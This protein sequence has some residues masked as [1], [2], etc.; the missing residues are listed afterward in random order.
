MDCTV[1]NLYGYI[2]DFAVLCIHLHNNNWWMKC[3]EF[4]SSTS[5]GQVEYA[6][7]L[8]W[9]QSVCRGLK[10]KTRYETNWFCLVQLKDRHL[11]FDL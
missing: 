5:N 4:A 9:V 10:T 6:I 8:D 11:Y 1:E 3:S 7:F 2:L